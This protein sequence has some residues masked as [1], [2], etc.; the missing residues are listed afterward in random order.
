MALIEIASDHVEPPPYQRSKRVPT[1]LVLLLGSG[2]ASGVLE[3]GSVSK[4]ACWKE[5]PSLKVACWK[6]VPTPKV[7]C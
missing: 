2:W 1:Y 7:A 6:E 3:G 5:V 4:V